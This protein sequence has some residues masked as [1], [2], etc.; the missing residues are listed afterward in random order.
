VQK[1]TAPE[2]PPPNRVQK[3]TAPE[4]PPPRFSPQLPPSTHAPYDV[5]WKLADTGR[6]AT[7]TFE[8]RPGQ[9]AF[10]EGAALPIV[11]ENCPAC[12]DAPKERY[13]VKCLL[14]TQEAAFPM[15]FQSLTKCL[16]PLMEPGVED[17][18]RRRREAYGKA[19]GPV[20]VPPPLPRISGADD[21]AS[22]AAA[23]LASATHRQYNAQAAWSASLAVSMQPFSGRG[24]EKVGATGVA[25]GA[26]A[27]APPP[28]TTE[29]FGGSLDA[30]G[31]FVRG[32]ADA[33]TTARQHR[34]H[35]PQPAA[36]DGEDGGSR[37]RIPRSVALGVAVVALV[38]VASLRAQRR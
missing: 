38:A 28:E 37:A 30:A 3:A 16:L 32:G 20:H 36:P 18:L 27:G 6:S 12:F 22:A 14:A 13:R 35:R 10:A 24:S 34:H 4:P 11:A 33:A 19:S 29:W 7:H 23:R 15:L 25:A 21:A 5:L 17:F 8:P 9:E 31:R 1:A 2:P 26:A